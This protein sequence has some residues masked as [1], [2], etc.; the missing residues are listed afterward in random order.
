MAP[1]ADLGG[2]EPPMHEMLGLTNPSDVPT[3]L[4]SPPF[5]EVST[6]TLTALGADLRGLGPLSMRDDLGF[7]GPA[8]VEPHNSQPQN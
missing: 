1:D 8:Y 4:L 3:N 2:L 5:Q 6:E 7:M